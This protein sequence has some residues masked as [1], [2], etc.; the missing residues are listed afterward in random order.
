MERKKEA[1]ESLNAAIDHGLID[2]EQINT[3]DAL[4]CL[5]IQEKT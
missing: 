2:R 5:H 3:R 4:L 1:F